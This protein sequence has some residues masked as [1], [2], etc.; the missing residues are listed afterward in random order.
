MNKAYLSIGSN[1]NDRYIN[2]E[3]C[4]RM[5]EKNNSSILKQSSIY[6]TAPIGNINQDFFYNIVVYIQTSLNLLDF[7]NKTKAIEL[8]M[9]RKRSQSRNSSRIIDIDILTFTDKIIKSDT[10]ILPHPRL[11]NRKFVLIPWSEI[12]N[13]FIVPSH[14]KSVDT[15]LKNVKDFSKVCKLNI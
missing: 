6:E 15:L 1:L 5:L 14:N 10:L 13:E 11:H 8:Q 9:G 3:K 7:F 12:G 4:I 2:I